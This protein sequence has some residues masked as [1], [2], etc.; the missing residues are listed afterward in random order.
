[1]ARGRRRPGVQREH[2]P[3]VHEPEI[4]H[5]T[6]GG[7]GVPSTN[8]L[9]ER[10]STGEH[11]PHILDIAGVPPANVLIERLSI[12]EHIFHSFDVAGVNIREVTFGDTCSNVIFGEGTLCKIVFLEFTIS[13]QSTTI[14]GSKSADDADSESDSGLGRCP[15]RI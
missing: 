1:V 15:L 8:I 6:R 7:A 5:A 4:P 14:G 2:L 12:R 3:P 13:K 9:I 11:T 10:F